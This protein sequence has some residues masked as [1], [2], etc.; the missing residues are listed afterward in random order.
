M[1]L[2]MYRGQRQGERLLLIPDVAGAK[3]IWGAQTNLITLL[4]QQRMTECNC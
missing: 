2:V 4:M 1:L 3:E